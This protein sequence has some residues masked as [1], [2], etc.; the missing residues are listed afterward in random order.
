MPG[1]G[2]SAVLVGPSK[3]S[4]ASKPFRWGF[5]VFFELHL[6][7]LRQP[8]RV[9]QNLDSPTNAVCASR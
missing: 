4:K 7:P 2:A 6:F 1:L 8:R 3:G 5:A 9:M